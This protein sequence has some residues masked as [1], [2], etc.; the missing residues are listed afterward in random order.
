MN[1]NKTTKKINE[2][3]VVV[4]E[5]IINQEIQYIKDVYDSKFLNLRNIL[6]Q[7]IKK[8]QLLLDNAFKQS[9]S[10]DLFLV[11]EYQ[12]IYTLYGMIEVIGPLNP[13]FKLSEQLSVKHPIV[14]HGICYEL[15]LES[16]NKNLKNFV[17]AIIHNDILTIMIDHNQKLSIEFNSV[18][19]LP[20]LFPISVNI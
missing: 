6:R 20:G 5:N 3:K 19:S 17:N 9:I 12:N 10:G 16:P 13:V 4:G 18:I 7:P 15:N 11:Q 8:H 1:I 14:I 2:Q